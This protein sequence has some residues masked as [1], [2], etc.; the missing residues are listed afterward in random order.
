MTFSV[1]NISKGSTNKEGVWE[2]NRFCSNYN[3]HI[4]GIA[5]KLLAYFKNNY[6]WDEIFSYA[7]KRWS[8]GNLYYQLGFNL[9]HETKPNYWY[10]KGLE[11]I[12]RFNLRKKENEPKDI[13]EWILRQNEGYLKVW[14]C[15]N[16][17]FRMV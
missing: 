12:H 9:E 14:D 11:R 16:L 8:N 17:K 6:M 3:Y 13:P 10:V 4:P 15:G 5:S 2:L 7:D 1:G